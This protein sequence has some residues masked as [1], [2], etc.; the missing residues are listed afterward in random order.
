MEPPEESEYHSESHESRS[1]NDESLSP[2]LN[3]NASENHIEV[4]DIGQSPSPQ[5]SGQEG[6]INSLQKYNCDINSKR[7]ASKLRKF[8]SVEYAVTPKVQQH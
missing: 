1:Q 4:E 2:K 6:T 3:N 8:G 5:K 7:R